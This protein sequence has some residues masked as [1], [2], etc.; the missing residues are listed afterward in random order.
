[1]RVCVRV[2]VCVVCIKPLH[3]SLHDVRHH[4]LCAPQSPIHTHHHPSTLILIHP[5]PPHHTP[6]HTPPPP[7]YEGQPHTLITKAKAQAEWGP[8]ALDDFAR[9]AYPISTDV[10]CMWSDDPT[11]W[12]PV[13]H[14]CDP[15]CWF[16][17]M[18]GLGAV[19]LKHS[20]LLWRCF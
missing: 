12:R 4:S 20:L 3:I 14:S 5:H 7:R 1:M 8:E 19:L 18:W 10:W 9:Y 17:G 11:D 16:G 15:N 6:T 13:N 2:H